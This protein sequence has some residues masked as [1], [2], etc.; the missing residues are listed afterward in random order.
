MPE[1]PLP[2]ESSLMVISSVAYL[3][4]RDCMISGRTVCPY[5]CIRILRGVS[6]ETKSRFVCSLSV[7][8]K[9][10]QTMQATALAHQ[11]YMRLV[12]G[13]DQS[14]SRRGHF[15]KAAAEAMRRILVENV[16]RKKSVK[17]DCITVKFLTIC[18]E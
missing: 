18:H 17:A 15:F 3:Y 9:P 5:Q 14:S 8:C 2:H 10:G 11:A 4:S 12:E 16:R 1:L 6:V 13:E 7:V